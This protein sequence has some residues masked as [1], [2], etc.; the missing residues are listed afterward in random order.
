MKAATA[1][2]GNGDSI[3][4]FIA[5]QRMPSFCARYIASRASPNVEPQAR[6][7]TWT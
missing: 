5:A 3:T 7:P 1:S 6:M 4:T 2:V